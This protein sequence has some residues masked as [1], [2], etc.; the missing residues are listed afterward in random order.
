MSL[1]AFRR[2]LAP[3]PRRPCRPARA[4]RPVPIDAPLPPHSP[5]YH[6][7]SGQGRASF[8]ATRPSSVRRLG[9]SVPCWIVAEGLVERRVVHPTC[10]PPTCRRGE[11]LRG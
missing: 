3:R 11:P 1:G 10:T 7:G 2:N 4:E 5:N 9:N 6:S 8:G